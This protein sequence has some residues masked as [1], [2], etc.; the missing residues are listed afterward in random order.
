MELNND[1]MQ[2]NQYVDQESGEDEMEDNEQD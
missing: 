2:H 1:S